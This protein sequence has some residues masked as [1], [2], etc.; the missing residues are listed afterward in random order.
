[1]QEKKKK[2]TKG[3][4]APGITFLHPNTKA[5]SDKEESLARLQRQEVSFT[6]DN[7]QQGNLAQ[8][9]HAS[10]ADFDLGPRG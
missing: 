10:R 5:I 8:N 2:Y 1:M 6:L 4:S 3:T 7:K 9:P